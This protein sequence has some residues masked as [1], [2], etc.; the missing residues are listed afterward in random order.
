MQPMLYFVHLIA[1]SFPSTPN[2]LEILPGHAFRAYV[3]KR[4]RRLPIVRRRIRRHPRQQRQ[5]NV[6]ASRIANSRF[7]MCLVPSFLSC[8]RFHLPHLC[9]DPLQGEFKPHGQR[10]EQLVHHLLGP[11]A[12]IQTG[13]KGQRSGYVFWRRD[14]R[15]LWP[16]CLILSTYLGTYAND[17][18]IELRKQ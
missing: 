2:N 9:F 16:C 17:I 5:R 18:I 14:W 1:F 7:F 12:D 4:F 6:S 15:W 8:R 11:L 13:H 3:P 10:R